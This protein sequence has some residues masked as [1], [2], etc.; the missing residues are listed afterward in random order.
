MKRLVIVGAD[1]DMQTAVR[2]H[3][4]ESPLNNTDVIF[5]EQGTLPPDLTGEDKIILVQAGG[6]VTCGHELMEAFSSP[7]TREIEQGTLPRWPQSR[8]GAFAGPPPMAGG[9][10][11][12]NRAA[13][14]GRTR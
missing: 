7:V 12:N 9:T 3:M 13:R 1:Q 6:T 10:F 11:G 2:A 4:A 8:R 5:V 14:R